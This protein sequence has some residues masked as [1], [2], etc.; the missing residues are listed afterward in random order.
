[1]RCLALVTLVTLGAPSALGCA[2]ATEN[3]VLTTKQDS[4]VLDTADTT[5]ADTTE[6]DTTEADTGSVADSGLMR[7]AE[8]PEP[9]ALGTSPWKPT[10]TAPTGFEGRY[11]HS[12]VWTGTEMIVFG[13]LGATAAK[14]DGAAYDPAKNSW[15]VI[16]AA[17]AHFSK[18]RKQHAAVWTGSK[19]IVWG[20]LDTDNYYATTNAAY[21][22]TS[23]TWSDVKTVAIAGRSSPAA[24]WT[25]SEMLIWGGGVND[26][27]A[28]D[29]GTDAWTMIPASP[30]S[31]RS[32]QSAV[33]NGSRLIVWSGCPSGVVCA[34]DGA[35]YDPKTK[36]WT[37]MPAPPAGMDGR[38]STVAIADGSG[39]IFWGGYGGTDVSNLI[40]KTGARWDATGWKSMA[41]A[42]SVMTP[43]GGRQEALAWIASGKLH[44]FG[45]RTD[46]P[47]AESG[48][49]IYDI[50]ADKWS[51][52]PSMDAPSA[53][54]HATV[55]WTG[56]DAVIWGGTLT[57]GVP[58][59]ILRDGALYRP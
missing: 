23:D 25:G 27:A 7:E 12:A 13:G 4:G 1:M 5:R 44:V 40:K 39:A 34:N 41:T 18:G 30:L 51:A 56:T 37:L 11:F 54:V 14:K 52:L 46:Y 43:G 20:G 58:S 15:R 36:T 29:P 49:A 50:A 53:R 33:W 59:G 28:Y 24:V 55:V 3:D 16:A 9:D 32:G 2:T 10:A 22:P 48:G 57:P 42:E 6:T 47:S 26:G 8:T 45:G 35:I 17:P 31:V 38:F 21:D 19:M